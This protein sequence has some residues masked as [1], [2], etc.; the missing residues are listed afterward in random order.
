MPISWSLEFMLVHLSNSKSL[1]VPH[2]LL[3]LKCPHIRLK[4]SYRYRRVR[5]RC[6]PFAVHVSPS[7]S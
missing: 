4:W 3:L 5:P 2:I 7:A 1:S 6:Y